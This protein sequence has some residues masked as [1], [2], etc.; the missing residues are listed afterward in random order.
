MTCNVPGQ[1]QDTMANKMKM[2]TLLQEQ[3]GYSQITNRR[4]APRPS[5]L[6][7][8]KLR[9]QAGQPGVS[10]R[11]LV[12]AVDSQPASTKPLPIKINHVKPST[13]A[14]RLVVR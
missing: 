2:L 10:R 13:G 5:V 1:E 12:I 7:L 9:A 8:Q 3:L 14:T 4:P 11:R 6:Y